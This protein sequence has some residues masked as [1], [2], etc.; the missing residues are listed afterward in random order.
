M[1]SLQ[2]SRVEAFI[3]KPDLN[4]TAFLIYGPD[5]GLV[6]ER[7]RAIAKASGADLK[8]PFSF[9]RVSADEIASEPGRL[10][11]EANA[12]GLFGGDRLIWIQGSTQKDITKQIKPVLDNPPE[13]ARLIIEAGD[14][15]KSAGLR[16]TLEAHKHAICIPCYPDNDAALDR[17][18]DQEVVGAG[19][20]IAPEV[21][22]ELKAMLGENRQLSRNELSKLACYCLDTGI[23]EMENVKLTVGDASGLVI[24]D[25]I[26][27]ISVGNAKRFETLFDKA[28]QTAHKPDI[29]LLSTLKHFQTLHGACL[30]MERRQETPST[31]VQR[32]QPPLHFSRRNNVSR[33]LTIWKPDRIS[34]VLK[35]L[36]DAILKCRQHSSGAVATA[37]M[38]L[39]AICLEARAQSRNFR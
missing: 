31:L 30:K 32:F 35:R 25:L 27:H 39:L 26:D 38:A 28:V 23:V 7:A 3:A 18:I 14:L 2:A 21:R 36:N 13:A 6:N 11:D 24:T 37:S 1:A 17:L 19:L 15:K 34:K 8:D 29:I 33:A 12:I 16:K 20:K 22:I 4:F 10:A 5:T 9:L